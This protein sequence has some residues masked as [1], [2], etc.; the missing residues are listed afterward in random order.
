MQM[1]Y[2]LFIVLAMCILPTA[3]AVAQETHEIVLGPSDHYE[4]SETSQWR[5]D[6]TRESSERFADVRIKPKQAGDF[7]LML[8]FLSDTPELGRLNTPA[9]IAAAVTEAAEQYL[10]LTVE[11]KV[12]L[13]AVS[14]RGSYGSLAVLTAANLEGVPGEFKYQTRG[15]VR[16]SPDAALGFSLLSKEVNTASYRQLL[17][18]VYSFIKLAP[19]MTAKPS[20]A[21]PAA[22]PSSAPAHSPAKSQAESGADLTSA[23]TRAAKPL[24]Q[25][26][27]QDVRD[28]LSLP[29][30]ADVMRC[31]GGHK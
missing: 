4:V 17:N 18:Y 14:P 22:L 12:S 19:N 10:P 24:P 2:S 6:V 5:F 29:T 1:E 3:A 27:H 28:C 8:Y 31:V 26:S 20:A 16:L 30:D 23:P 15:M 7:S 21:K 25:A 13:Q 9:K 11:K